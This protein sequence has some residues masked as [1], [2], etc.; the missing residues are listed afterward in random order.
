LLSSLFHFSDTESKTEDHCFVGFPAIWNIVAF[1]VFA[2][3]MP[4]W[5]ASLLV[6]ACVV[7]TFVPLRWA[8]PLRTPLLWPVTLA[9]MGVWVWAAFLTLWSG[10]PAGPS[11]QAALLLVAAYGVGLVLLRSRSGNKPA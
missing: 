3:H 7:L 11:A 9:L 5:A 4:I 2:F 10:F 6:L 1:Y 8:H